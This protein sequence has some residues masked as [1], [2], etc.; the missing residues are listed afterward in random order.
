MRCT[1]CSGQV[2]AQG[3]GD[4]GQM[5]LSLQNPRLLGQVTWDESMGHVL[6]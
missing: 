5:A 2:S 1:R 4:G 3:M 6:V